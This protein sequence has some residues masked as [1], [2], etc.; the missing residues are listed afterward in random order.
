MA[1]IAALL[2]GILVIALF[3]RKFDIRA[4]VLLLLALIAMTV[5][6]VLGG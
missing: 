5:A 2:A 4:R 6:V 1:T 3:M